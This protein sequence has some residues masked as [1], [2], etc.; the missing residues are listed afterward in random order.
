M[1]PVTAA[2]TP[3]LKGSRVLDAWLL[4]EVISIEDERFVL[5]IENATKRLL[6]V[7]ALGH[8]V[9]FG[10]VEAAGANQI[11]DV[12]VAFKQLAPLGDLPVLF[13]NRRVQVIDL[14]FE[15]ER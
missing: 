14:P 13:Y 11:P 2:A 4:I 10:D 3:S 6:C 1:L 9:D 15:C 12:A 8:I 7:A 5:G